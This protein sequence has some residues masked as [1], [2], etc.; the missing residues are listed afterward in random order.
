MAISYKILGQATP[1]NSTDTT[2]Y[3]VPTGKQAI[4][5][6]IVFTAGDGQ[7]TQGTLRIYAMKSGVSANA[8]ANKIYNVSGTV[9]ARSNYQFTDKITLTAGESIAVNHNTNGEESG[10]VT[11]FGTEMDI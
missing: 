2:V 4:L 7:S 6:S 11:I 1:N 3:T 8:G 5:S 10:V 9:A